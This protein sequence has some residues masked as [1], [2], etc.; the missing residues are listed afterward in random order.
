MRTS[1]GAWSVAGLVAGY[2]GLAAA[3]FLAM[4]TTIRDAPN[5]AVAELVVRLTPGPV[6]E[7]AIKILGHNDAGGGAQVSAT[8]YDANSYMAEKRRALAQWQDLLARIVGE[9]APRD[10]AHVFVGTAGPSPG[11]AATVFPVARAPD[12]ARKPATRRQGHLR[13]CDRRRLRTALCRSHAR[14]RFGDRGTG[15]LRARHGWRAVPPGGTAPVPRRRLLNPPL[16]R[17]V[18]KPRLRG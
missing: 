7:R 14:H 10:P 13:R 11:F 15:G 3:Y 17:S 9:A 4:V 16:W 8:H 18:P 12:R 6:V 2:L 1:R 5:V